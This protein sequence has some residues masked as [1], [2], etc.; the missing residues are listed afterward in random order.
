MKAEEIILDVYKKKN[1]RREQGKPCSQVIMP[2]DFYKQIQDY[3]RRLGPLEGDLP[4]YITPDSLFGLEIL[5]DN[6]KE[7]VVS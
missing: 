5:I 1:E 7:T 6:R 4:D 3:H 2:M